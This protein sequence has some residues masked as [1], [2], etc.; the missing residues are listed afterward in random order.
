M[1]V[2]YLLILVLLNIR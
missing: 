1:F 2:V